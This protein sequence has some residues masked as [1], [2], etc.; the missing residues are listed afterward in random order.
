MHWAYRKTDLRAI[1][2]PFSPSSFHHGRKGCTINLRSPQDEGK[3]DRGHCPINEYDTR[4]LR[5]ERKQA[6]GSCPII[7]DQ[8]PRSVAVGVGHAGRPPWKISNSCADISEESCGKYV[9]IGEWSD[10]DSIDDDLFGSSGV[11]ACSSSSS[12]HGW[13]MTLYLRE[14]HLQLRSQYSF[15]VHFLCLVMMLY[16]P[17]IEWNRKTQKFISFRIYFLW[18]LE[19]TKHRI[20]K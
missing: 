14:H 7:T 3:Q 6:R 5:D 15:W 19:I 18:T 11:S 16:F 9:C 8:W 12:F 10:D 4:F 20:Q 13:P 1:V 2:N 17:F